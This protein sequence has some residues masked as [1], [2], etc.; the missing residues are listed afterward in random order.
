LVN[1]RLLAR[2]A[3]QMSHIGGSEG[4]TTNNENMKL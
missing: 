2:L 3:D 1:K 4:S